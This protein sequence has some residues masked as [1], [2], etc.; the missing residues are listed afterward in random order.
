V[1]IEY[2]SPDVRELIE[3]PYRIIYRVKADQVDVSAV[4]HGA[5]LPPPIQWWKRSNASR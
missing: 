2:E 1:V 3:R 4:I 5:R